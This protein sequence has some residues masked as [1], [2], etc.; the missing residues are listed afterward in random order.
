MFPRVNNDTRNTYIDKRNT[1]LLKPIKRKKMCLISVIFCVIKFKIDFYYFH[2]YF[3][4]NH[5]QID[6]KSNK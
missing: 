5:I 6:M 3:Y 1:W 4:K 2:G